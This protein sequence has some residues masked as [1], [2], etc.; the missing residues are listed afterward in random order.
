MLRGFLA[1][2]MLFSATLFAGIDPRVEMKPV[3]EAFITKMQPLAPIEVISQQPP[4]PRVE[5]PPPQ[6][7][8][9][10]MWIPGYWAWQRDAKAFLWVC[11]IWRLEP[12]G[13]HWNPGYWKQDNGWYWVAGYWQ[14]S[15]AQPVIAQKAPPNQPQEKTGNPPSKNHFWVPG[16][17][18]YNSAAQSYSW[19]GGSWQPFDSNVVF[20]P[21]YWQWRPE[22]YMFHPAF[23]DWTLEDR[24]VAYDCEG[25]GPL[26]ALPSE[27]ILSRIFFFYPDYTVFF[28]FHWHFHPHFWADCWCLPPWWMWD[29]W[30]SLDWMDQWW[31]WWWWAHAGFPPPPWMFPVALNQ[32]MPPDDD[33]L[34]FLDK[35]PKPPFFAPNGIPPFED[36]LDAIE[37]ETGDKDPL[38]P[39]DD[40][41]D[42]AEEAG[43]DL[44]DTDS[45]DRPSGKKPGGNVP[46]PEFDDTITP[47]G[48]A[49]VPP[50][51][52]RPTPPS[53]IAPVPI[54]PNLTPPR[55]YPPPS[56]QPPTQRPIRPW[57]QPERP[58]PNWNVPPQRPRPEFQPRPSR[59]PQTFHPRPS[60]PRPEFQPRPSR[61]PQTGPS[62][63][64]P[65]RTSRPPIQ[66]FQPRR[67]PMRIAPQH[68]PQFRPTPQSRPPTQSQPMRTAPSREFQ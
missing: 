62:E 50:S 28:W 8:P 44:P 13:H 57:I 4:T 23:W 58:R 55:S 61:P 26:V 47:D 60:R 39:E 36:W 54:K 32:M 2:F 37:E 6:P 31:L 5:A 42:A 41:D 3:H 40:L 67:G 11:G 15:S 10:M 66:S 7:H 51:Q 14:D 17:W 27:V 43:E 53:T 33:M 35:L 48:Q 38:I 19:L 46:K 24:G 30:W 68:R 34:D 59:P 64:N 21:A 18:N 52:P 12:S 63:I 25:H 45:S 56:Y 22:G 9:Q 29:A 16:Y 1:I 49:P 65:G 20:V